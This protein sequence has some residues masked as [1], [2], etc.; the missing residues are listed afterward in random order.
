MRLTTRA[1]AAVAVLGAWLA[2]PACGGSQ[3]PDGL[4][5]DEV[6][7]AWRADYD[8]LA[9]RCSRCHSL[10]RVFNARL[11]DDQWGAYV[12]RMRRMP[13]SGI[14]VKDAERVLRFLLWYN[15]KLRAR[16]QEPRAELLVSPAAEGTP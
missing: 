15:G 14:S 5:A 1:R 2:I 12:T 6:P 10:T 3:R 16:E 9:H 13:G 8:V 4:P 11:D 7:A